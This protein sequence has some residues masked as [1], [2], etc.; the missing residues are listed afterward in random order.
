MLRAPVLTACALAALAAVVACSPADRAATSS[1]SGRDAVAVPRYTEADIPHDSLGD[2][3]RRG[4]ALVRFTPE[5]LPQYATSNLR[6]T[7]CHQNDG[8]KASASPLIGT[9]ARY[10]KYLPRSGAVVT[11]ADR[12]NFCFTRSLAGNRLPYES[13]EMADIIAYLAFLSRGSPVWPPS[14]GGGDG[15]APMKD[16]L[17]GDT[18]RGRAL[19]TAKCVSCHQPDGGGT[20]PIPALW[21]ARS[22]AITASM[23]RQERAASFIMHNMP[24]SAPG[25]LTAQEAFD[26][27]AFINAQPRP[28]APNKGGDW[29]AGGAPKDVPYDTKGHVAFR[30]PARLLPRRSPASA[31]VPPP[32]HV[33]RGSN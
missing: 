24:Q 23:G 13:R 22:Y 6:C 18:L 25:T 27:S 21:G 5:S 14:K 1:G 33:A 17:V 31:L 29:P 26:L 19:Y 12:V 11:I 2:A 3:I 15:L 9:F 30:P 7:S 20:G 28:D 16:T 8:L 10:P 32:A 4:L